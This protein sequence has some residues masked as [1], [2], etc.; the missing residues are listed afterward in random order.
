MLTIKKKLPLLGLAVLLLCS[1]IL[2]GGDSYEVYVGN[3]RIIRQHVF[4]MKKVP[5][6]TLSEKQADLQMSIS[7]S[8]CGTVGKKRMITIRDEKNSVYKK[9]SYNDGSVAASLIGSGRVMKIPVSDILD[10]RKK[11]GQ[12]K[13]KIYYS[14]KELP[15]G[16]ELVIIN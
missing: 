7:Y 16:K 9:W 5:V 10:A 15:D 4:D 8:H 6:I 2:P 14:S 11:N 12:K 1:F 13:L 3:E